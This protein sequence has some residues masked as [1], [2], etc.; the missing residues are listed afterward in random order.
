MKH[1]DN[2]SRQRAPRGVI[3]Q[4]VL[5]IAAF[6]A[7]VCFL[8]AGGLWHHDD[9]NAASACPVCQVA[10]MPVTGPVAQPSFVVSRH[11]V[12]LAGQAEA[13][14]YVSPGLFPTSSRAPPIA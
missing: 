9:P 11:V 7:L 12:A 4:R 8:A 10:H 6:A 3:K 13:I 14:L 2:P 5:L 1:H